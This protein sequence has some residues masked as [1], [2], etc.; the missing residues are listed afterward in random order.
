MGLFSKSKMKKRRM[1]AELGSNH[2]QYELAECYHYG[3]DT[4]QDYR[5]AFKWYVEAARYKYSF[6]Y[7]SDG[8]L[9]AEAGAM[10]MVAI[11]YAEGRIVQK[12]LKF[13]FRLLE[14]LMYSIKEQENGRD[15]LFSFIEDDL[16]RKIKNKYVEIKIELI[17]SDNH[18]GAESYYQYLEV[19]NENEKAAMELLQ[20][21]ASQGYEDAVL[22]LA[23]KVTM[24]YTTDSA[25]F[26]HMLQLFSKAAKRGSAKVY[27]FLAGYYSR[28]YI[29][30]DK[31]KTNNKNYDVHKAVAHYSKAA[32][33]GDL[34]SACK[35]GEAYHFGELGLNKDY[36]MAMECLF[37]VANRQFCLDE[38]SQIIK[39]REGIGDA[40]LQ[41]DD[42]TQAI[43]WYE[44][45]LELPWDDPS[46]SYDSNICWS[47]GRIYSDYL[48][49]KA[50]AIEWFKRG[51][52]HDGNANCKM[53]MDNIGEIY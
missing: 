39:A 29:Y 17:N 47:I 52:R 5:E 4:P 32:S 46:V 20:Y 35:L 2:Y 23:G 16:I 3:K 13:A 33:L 18:P 8:M 53:E 38:N 45:A 12:N 19:K 30:A 9:E 34:Y 11:Y 40:L 37:P 15:G 27:R 22:E 25:E 50:K 21:S 41:L 42:Y 43:K 51:I 7:S 36:N 48:N 10:Y 14:K 28:E 26:E 1:Y 31:K 49:Q 44:K 24:N 6:R